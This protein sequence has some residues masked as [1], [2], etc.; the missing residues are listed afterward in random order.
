[1]R[2]I[3]ARSVASSMATARV[4]EAARERAIKATSLSDS[5]VIASTSG[6]SSIMRRRAGA[7]RAVPL[8]SAPADNP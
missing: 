1:V 4:R 5:G 3:V 6:G 7:F 2:A 8:A